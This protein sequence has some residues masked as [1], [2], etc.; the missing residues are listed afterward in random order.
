MQQDDVF[1]YFA[2]WIG[3]ALLN[4]LLFQVS[5]DA[6]FKRK[7]YPWATTFMGALYLGFIALHSSSSEALLVMVPFVGVSTYTNI[8]MTKFCDSCGRTVRR[9]FYSTERNCPKC[10]AYLNER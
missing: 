2:I 3:F 1:Q 4:F 6:Q 5:T 9:G 7:Y 10:G 8:R